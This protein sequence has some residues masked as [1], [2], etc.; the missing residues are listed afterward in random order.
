MELPVVASAA[1]RSVPVGPLT[2]FAPQSGYDSDGNPHSLSSD[3]ERGVGITCFEP[4]H[5]PAA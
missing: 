5:G 1:I 3:I 4:E 2:R